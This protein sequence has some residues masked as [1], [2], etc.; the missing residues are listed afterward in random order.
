MT[1]TQWLKAATPILAGA[2]TLASCSDTDD[3]ASTAAP[4]ATT[5]TA[6]L[7]TTGVAPTADIATTDDMPPVGQP[8]TSAAPP[9]DAWDPAVVARCGHIWEGVTTIP[10][11]ESASAITTWANVW[12][13]HL[14][15]APAVDESGFPVA[16]VGDVGGYDETIA[17]AQA[18]LADAAAAGAAGDAD[19]ALLAGERADELVI[20]SQLMLAVAGAPC[21]N[22]P[23]RFTGATLNVPL[24]GAWQVGTGFDSVWVSKQHSGAVARVDPASGR[25]LATID[26]AST[27]VK[28]QPADGRMW[29]RTG[30]AYVAIDPATNSVSSTLAK[31]DVGPEANRSWAVDGALW[32]CDGTRLHRYDPTTVTP[33]TTL[34]LGI[35]CGQVFAT[36][37]LAVA[38]TYNEDDGE[39]GASAAVF[40][41]PATNAVVAEVDLPVDVGVPVVTDEVVFFPGYGNPGGASV[42][43]QSWSVA[44]H[45]FDVALG[46]S[47]S[48]TDGTFIYVPTDDG[49]NIAVIDTR[50]HQLLDMIEPLE[51]NSVVATDDGLW[52]VNHVSS[53][54]QRFDLRT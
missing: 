1:R 7:S 11:A 15:A 9:D 13:D 34:D 24:L 8:S 19:G 31:A 47:Q 51:V 23:A 45:R 38:W 29:V 48:T 39:S 43:R 20:Q 42:D 21:F 35:E 52:A 40:I 49:F 14:D 16:T 28:L 3:A 4:S 41:D 37:H 30:D 26:V 22:E 54:L 5:A 50:S 6:D 27:P 53:Y 32:I 25:V 12:L 17:A 10:W 18:A 2:L 46:G 36:P 33:V 44:E